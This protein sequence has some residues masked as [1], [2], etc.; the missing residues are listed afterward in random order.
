[1]YSCRSAF[2]LPLFH[3]FTRTWI[4]L[5]RQLL[6]GKVLLV[7]HRGE[8]KQYAMKMMMKDA[9]VKGNKEAEVT[10]E[11]ETMISIEH[12]FIVQVHYA[13]HNQDRLFLVVDF[14]PGGELYHHLKKVGSFSEEQAC[15]ICA[16]ISLALGYGAA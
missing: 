7:R 11:L 1:M 9:I 2:S 16:E 6:P 14:M 4:D 10:K 12:P 15:F 8:K 13:F 3:H 5:E